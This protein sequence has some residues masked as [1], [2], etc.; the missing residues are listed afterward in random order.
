MKKTLS[1]IIFF[2]FTLNTI[3]AGNT[4]FLEQSQ[5]DSVVIDQGEEMDSFGRSTPRGTVD[6]FLKSLANSDY[7]RASKFINFPKTIKS[8]QI[9][10]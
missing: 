9:Q 5:A 2:V 8:I 1:L 6:G 4:E 3:H 10:L 7:L